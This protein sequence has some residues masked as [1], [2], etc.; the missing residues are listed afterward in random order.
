MLPTKRD[1]PMAANR[2]EGRGMKVAILFLALTATAQVP[3]GTIAGVVRDPSGAAVSGARVTVVYLA[4]KIARTET[5]SEQ[6][7]YSFAA[8]IPGDY[9][10]TVQADRFASM[11]RTASA[12]SGATTAADFDLKLGDAKTSITVEAIAPQIQYDSHSVS[13][14]ITGSEIENLPLNGRNFLELAKLEPGVQSPLRTSGNRTLVPV[15]GGP[16]GPSGSGT[17]VTVDGSSI[18]TPGLFGA[19]MN[20][21]QDLVQEFQVSEANYDLSTGTTFSGAINVVTRSGGNEW[22]SSAFYFFRDHKLSGYPGLR[23]DPANPDPFFQRQQYGFAAGGPIR[24]DRLFFFANWERNDQRGVAATTLA[25]GD[26]AHFSGIT[27]TP[28]SENQVSF[29]LDDRLSAN[30]T[31]FARYSHDGDR[32]FSAVSGTAGAVGNTYPSNWVREVTWVDQSVLGVTSILRPALV[33]DFRYSYYFLSDKQLPPQPSDCSGCV[34]I[35]AP[36][37]SVPTA[38]LTIGQSTTTLYPGRRLQLNDS[39]SW[40]RGVHRMRFGVD[41][42]FNRGGALSWMNEPAT[43]TLFSP[44]QVRTYN[45]TAPALPIPLPAAF[46]TLNDIL[47]LPLASVTIGIGDPRTRQANGGQVR[48]WS[49]ARLY[50][51]DSWCLR[52]DLTLNYGLAWMVDGYQNYDLAKPAFL[53]PIL[54]TDGIGPTRRNW[55]NFSPSLGFAWA[56]AHDRKTVIHG[57]AGIYYDFFF[58]DMINTERALLEPAGSGRQTILGS[59]IGNPLSGIPGVPATTPLN[60]TTPTLFTGANL[61]SVL[62]AIR[63]QLS[64]SL[65]N[66]DPPL[67]SVQVLKQVAGQTNI[68][69]PA[70]LP[71]WS[72]QQFNLGIQRELARDFVLSASGVFRHFIHGGLG[73]SGLDLNQFFSARGPVIPRCKGTQQDDPTALCSTG[74]IQV[75]E[76]TSNQQ[77]KGLLVRA[78]KRF[79]RGFQVLGSWAWSRNAGTP[80]TGASNPNAA[81]APTGLN[82]DHWHQPLRPLILDF[83]HMVNLAGVAQLPW[84][85]ELGLNFSYSSAPP[86]SPILG[87]IDFNG[88]G[89]SGDLL[90]GTMLGQFNRALGKTDL[91][92]LVDQFNQTYGLTP[93]ALGRIIPRVTLPGSYSLDHNS[94]ALDLR[95]SRTFLFG[96]RERLSLIGEVFNLYNAANLSG[97]TT[98]LTN[99]A[100]GQPNGRFTQ[101]F[102]SGGPRA[103]QLAARFSF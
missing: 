70:N 56:P 29:R 32:N 67:T 81:F 96:E 71:H 72:S 42:E 61:M 14:V 37:I 76:A 27:P 50:F 59:A 31:M 97:Y 33:N 54:G 44:G 52:E 7:A 39:M 77:Y 15:L 49:T 30:H 60:F 55:K 40:Q 88:D 48:T 12:E 36:T 91:A 92:R 4:T 98:D 17:R 99:P 35:G 93:D 43:L 21:S 25:G 11:E 38:G 45:S 57:G 16:G 24:R 101:L 75:Y 1:L 8:L 79:S 68:L 65:A 78:D 34:G 62:P 73:P 2:E 80:G 5:T 10:L 100:F 28:L 18:M 20:F 13:G 9:K 69:F 87:G 94:Q 51:Q 84:H 90:P 46:Q 53:A 19:S 95:L 82:L 89:T 64:S 23:R 102:G 66:P 83:T 86:F 6:G 85:F 3:T 103:F 74:P 47:Q 63:A 58:A 22:H 41:W 26:F